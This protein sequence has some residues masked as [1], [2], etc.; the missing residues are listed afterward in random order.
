MI[1]DE[2]GYDPDGNLVVQVFQVEQQRFASPTSR[3]VLSDHCQRLSFAVY[4]T[5]DNYIS[6][7]NQQSDDTSF[8]E[9]RFRLE[10][11]T[12]QLV[13]VGHSSS[14]APSMKDLHKI[15]FKN[16]GGFSDTFL[17]HT[18]IEVGYD[19]ATVQADLQ[20]IVSL[21]RVV[22]TDP[23]PDEVKEINFRYVGG[24]G[25]FDATT[26][27]GSA[28]STQ[29]MTFPVEGGQHPST[30]DLYTILRDTE[31]TLQLQVKA[32]DANHD[33]YRDDEFQVPM[34]QRTITK[35]TG[36]FFTGSPNTP[37]HIVIGINDEWEGEETINF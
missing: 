35:L 2:A 22:F 16:A 32:F 29:V 12:Y 30:F 9:V 11:G 4:D 26:G 19:E 28:N 20:R 25:T 23:I 8:G 33:I 27:L 34:K 10:P 21:C 13:V 31:A 17:Y 5:H 3:S 15:Y 1:P 7:V 18:Q 6:Q 37:I 24:S 36:A 14:E